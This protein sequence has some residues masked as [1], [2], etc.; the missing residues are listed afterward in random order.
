LVERLVRNEKVRG[1]T[2]LG[3]TIHQRRALL[4]CTSGGRT[5]PGPQVLV[6]FVHFAVSPSGLLRSRAPSLSPA[7]GDYGVG[8]CWTTHRIAAISP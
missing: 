3:S 6:C 4:P 5:R 7:R 2:P 8:P 1:S